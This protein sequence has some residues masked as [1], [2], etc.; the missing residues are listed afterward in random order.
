[1]PSSPA[2]VGQTLHYWPMQCEKSHDH[3]QPFRAD[4]CHVNA[5]GTVNLVICNEI[6]IASR[7]TNIPVYNRR[8]ARSGEASPI[9]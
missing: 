9:A 5:N 7:R 8:A 1:M 3:D 6:G 4:V 2:Y